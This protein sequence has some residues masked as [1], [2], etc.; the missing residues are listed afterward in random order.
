MIYIHGGSL[1]G[2]DFFFLI[3][4]FHDTVLQTQ[5][6]PFPYSLFPLQARISKFFI[7]SNDN[8]NCYDNTNDSYHHL[9]NA[10]HFLSTWH[11]L[12]HLN[13]GKSHEVGLLLCMFYQMG[14]LRCEE[15]KE[16]TYSHR[17]SEWWCHRSE[18]V[19]SLYS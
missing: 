17:A 6:I 11:A 16:L 1:T 18:S 14:K 13:T 15:V 7:N 5:G 2:W 4:N 19:K 9:L 12:Y 10:C 3:S 8:N